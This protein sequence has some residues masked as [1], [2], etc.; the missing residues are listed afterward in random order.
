MSCGSNQAIRR[1]NRF[2]QKFTNRVLK[3]RGNVFY[4]STT[5]SKFSK[6]WTYTPNSIIIYTLKGGRVKE[7]LVV[8]DSDLGNINEIPLPLIDDSEVYYNNDCPLV[9][10]G[11]VFG[12]DIKQF[13]KVEKQAL[14]ININE[15]LLNK[16]FKNDFFN[17]VINDIISYK[18]W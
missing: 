6:V 13:N 5:Y 2:T 16:K 12:Y 9:I 7:R 10:D 18:L 17:K 8:S 1:N 15:C 11:D 3:E 14:A 4:L